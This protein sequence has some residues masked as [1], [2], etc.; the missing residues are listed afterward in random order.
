MPAVSFASLLPLCDTTI[1]HELLGFIEIWKV[2]DLNLTDLH[3]KLRTVNIDPKLW[4]PNTNSNG[5]TSSAGTPC[6]SKELLVSTTCSDGCSFGFLPHCTSHIS[7]GGKAAI[8]LGV[9]VAHGSFQC[10]REKDRMWLKEVTRMNH[11]ACSLYRRVLVFI[12]SR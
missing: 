1:R 3:P 4:I 7:P 9:L 12:C 8:E 5:K 6:F 2:A 11:T 10:T